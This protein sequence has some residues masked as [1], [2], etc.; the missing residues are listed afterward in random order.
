[1]N[2]KEKRIRILNL[3]DQYCK[4]CGYQ[5]KPLTDCVPCCA[6]GQELHQLARGLIQD[7]Q[8]RRTYTHKEWHVICQQATILYEKGVRFRTIAKNLG[9]PATTL[10]EQLKKRGL[11]KGQTQAEIQERSRKK[12]DYLCQKALELREQGWSYEKIA[13]HLGV[14]SS[15]LRNQMRKREFV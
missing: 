3:Q 8:K 12:W 15:N 6:I 4:R 11:W 7:E 1:M 5:T 13:T 9:C 2:A 10:R 14:P